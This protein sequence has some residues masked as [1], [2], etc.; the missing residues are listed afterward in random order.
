MY[1]P[2]INNFFYKENRNVSP[3]MKKYI[4]S[5]QKWTCNIC[6]NILSVSYEIDHTTSL[7]FGGTNNVNNL[8]ALCR[9]CHGDKTI[10]EHLFKNHELI[11][12]NNRNNNNIDNQD[13]Q[14]INNLNLIVLDKFM[15]TIVLIYC[16]IK[17]YL[18]KF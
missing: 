5:N 6:K 14:I 16:I 12:Q 17:K 8:Q 1:K 11:Y 7:N 13:I 4:A 2:S 9:N 15:N 18:I 3:L 10:Y